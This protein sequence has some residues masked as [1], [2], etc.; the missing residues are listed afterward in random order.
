MNFETIINNPTYDELSKKIICKYRAVIDKDELEQC[1]CIGI[2]KA[3]TGFNDRRGSFTSYL[4]SHIGWEC[5]RTINN[6]K[7]QYILREVDRPYNDILSD[8][9]S[10]YG[11]NIELI[12]DILIYRKTR[13]ELAAEQNTSPSSINRRY[14]KLLK[15]LKQTLS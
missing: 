15:Q 8:D 4:C 9:L 13:R 7:T 11:Y 2:W 5:I 1:R 3:C 12:A 10:E 14:K 6:N